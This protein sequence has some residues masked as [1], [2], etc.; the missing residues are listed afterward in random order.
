SP[1]PC[2]R[3]LVRERGVAAAVAKGSTHAVAGSPIG[4][5]SIARTV[6]LLPSH[7][8]KRAR[9]APLSSGPQPEASRNGC[10]TVGRGG[11]IRCKRVSRCRVRALGFGHLEPRRGRKVGQ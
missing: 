3:S 10:K 9:A 8:R 6:G 5:A 4:E 11:G 2:S 7:G 1:L